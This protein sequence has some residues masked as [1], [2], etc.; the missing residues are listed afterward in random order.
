MA[1]NTSF[2][3][4]N[5]NGVNVF[6]N[7]GF[8]N[9]DE[10]SSSGPDPIDIERTTIDQIIRSWD[11][12]PLEFK[13]QIKKF[14]EHDNIDLGALSSQDLISMAV[15]ARLEIEHKRKRAEEEKS[16]SNG[17]DGTNY[18]G[19]N[20]TNAKSDQTGNNQSGDPVPTPPAS[21]ASQGPS[22]PGQASGNNGAQFPSSKKSKSPKKSTSSVGNND[23][24]N[25]SSNQ[26]NKPKKNLYATGKNKMPSPIKYSNNNSG[27]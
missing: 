17:I 8:G 20:S 21:P 12:A 22:S 10:V 5:D 23:I 26:Q 9:G 27:S 15:A 25:N 2:D 24:G 14:I 16:Q 1:E 7:V 11:E 18:N 6:E 3:N 13:Q 4:D 19:S